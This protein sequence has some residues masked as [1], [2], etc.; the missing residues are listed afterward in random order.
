MVAQ[1]QVNEIRHPTPSYSTTSAHSRRFRH[2]KGSQHQGSKPP[3]PKAGGPYLHEG[4]R[5]NY[6]GYADQGRHPPRPPSDRGG[7]RSTNQEVNQPL[8]YDVHE[9]INANIDARDHIKNS[10]AARYEAEMEC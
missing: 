7:N 6:E 3:R 10:R 1:V 5:G 9:H 2:D 4:P 8:P